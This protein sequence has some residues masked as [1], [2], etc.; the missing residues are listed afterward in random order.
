M[1]R[2]LLNR[3][4]ISAVVVALMLNC[5]V[6]ANAFGRSSSP[7]SIH[8]NA[9]GSLR[10][11][12]DSRH[13]GTKRDP[14]NSV[15]VISANN[16]WTV[17]NGPCC[18]QTTLIEH[19][20]GSTWSI[21]PSPNVES[22]YNF[23]LGVGAVSSNNV[24][25]VGSYILSSGTRQTL[26]EH[27]NGSYWSVVS[28]PNVGTGDNQLSSVT[29][30]SPTNVWAV[31]E[32]SSQTLIEHW[33][34][35]AWSVV[36]SPN[37]GK[38]VAL[39]GVAAV[40]PTNVWAVGEGSSQ[41]LIEHWN[42]SSWT[43]VPSPNGS[44]SGSSYLSGV[45]TVSS[46]NVWAVGYYSN[47]NS[48]VNAFQTLTEHWNGS[49]WSIVPSPNAGVGN[50]LFSVGAVSANDIWAVGTYYP[51]IIGGNQQTLIEHWNGSTWSIVPSPNVGGVTLFGV[52]AVSSNN[53]WAVGYYLDTNGSQPLIEHWNGSAWSEWATVPNITW[54]GYAASGSPFP[55][56]SQPT[57]VLYSDVKG[58]WTVPSAS[59]VKG[60]PS[61]EAAFWVGLGG[62]QGELEQIGIFINCNGSTGQ[63]SYNAVYE[64]INGSGTV[65]FIKDQYPK[66]VVHANDQISAEVKYPGNGQ[67]QLF[68]TD[69]TPSTSGSASN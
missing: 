6:I 35:T 16:I 54:A 60:Q 39:Y 21:V 46:N 53:V 28:S 7:S 37:V 40:S 68:M 10:S 26:I 69:T 9:T 64:I 38:G 24:W 61:S 27:W 57:S 13:I 50:Y 34:G 4:L 45:T 49:T 18:P 15:V 12:A 65:V 2:L 33:N 56:P 29:A 63:V 1:V 5:I 30:V 11:S 55:N 66:D 8:T 43:I 23:L 44:V 19:W 48:N 58:S 22:N 17:G 3:R 59:C 62:T 20:N 51:T 14:L 31:G 32:G 25:A 67:Y 52:G 41:T 36:P 47:T 42:G